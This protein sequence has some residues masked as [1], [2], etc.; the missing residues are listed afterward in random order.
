ML[1]LLL[2]LLLLLLP[3]PSPSAAF[4]LPAPSAPTTWPAP[5]PPSPPLPEDCAALLVSGAG[6]AEAN[7]VFLR[8]SAR[9]EG[10][11]VFA[12]DDSHQIYRTNV[13][14]T[15][16][17]WHLAHRGVAPCLDVGKRRF[18]NGADLG[19]ILGTFHLRLATFQISNSHQSLQFI[20]LPASE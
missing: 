20:H 11:P 3:P 16:R 18:H 4:A 2:P 13:S 14:A 8:T 5:L 19:V 9:S 10:A 12:K 6:A 1:L 7:G 15:A 17:E